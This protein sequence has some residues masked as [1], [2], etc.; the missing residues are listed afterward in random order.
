MFKMAPNIL[1]NLV[2]HKSTRRYP[3]EQRT[4]FRGARGELV[5]DMTKCNLCGVCAVKCPSQCIT[6]DK[7]A[8]TWGCDPFACLF[9]GICVESCPKQ[10]LMQKEHYRKPVTKRESISFSGR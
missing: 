8:G 9:C 4:P 6:V 7:G 1:R 5:N 10:S 3:L 2:V